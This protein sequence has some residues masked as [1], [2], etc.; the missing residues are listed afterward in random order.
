[1]ARPAVS[2]VSHTHIFS[3]GTYVRTSFFHDEVHILPVDDIAP[4]VTRRRN[5]VSNNSIRTGCHPLFSADLL[6]QGKDRED[7]SYNVHA[8]TSTTLHTVLIFFCTLKHANIDFKQYI[9]HNQTVLCPSEEGGCNP[10][11]RLRQAGHRCRRHTHRH[12]EGW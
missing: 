2:F 11:Y 8:P 9:Y 12:R 4:Q 10:L 3:L 6:L 5:Y 1:M 7:S